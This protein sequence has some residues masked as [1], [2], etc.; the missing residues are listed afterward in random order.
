MGDSIIL[1]EGD[2]VRVQTNE[3]VGNAFMRGARI[4]VQSQISASTV[5]FS[6]VNFTR[7]S[8]IETG[9]PLSHISPTFG[10]VSLK[11]QIKSETDSWAIEAF[12][13]FNTAKPLDEYGPGSTDNPQE[14]LSIGTPAWW[15]LNLES[16]FEISDNMHAQIGLSNLLDVHYKSFSSGISAPG[17]GVYF[18]IH[19]NF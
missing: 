6:T 7:G 17:R 1:Y 11:K 4:E 15:T 9:V 13:L 19:A 8:I 5:F 10:R 16:H 18:A 2:M 14:A 12:A 3:N